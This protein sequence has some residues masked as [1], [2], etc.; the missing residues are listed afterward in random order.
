M[1]K[2]QRTVLVSEGSQIV[3]SQSVMSIGPKSERES[4]GVF[5]IDSDSGGI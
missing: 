4:A 2:E 5:L 3:V 1:L